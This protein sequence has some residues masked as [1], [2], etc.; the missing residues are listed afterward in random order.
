MADRVTQAKLARG[1]FIEPGRHAT[2]EP[3]LHLLVRSAKNRQW[4]ARVTFHGRRFDVSIGPERLY[5]LVEARE[6]CRKIARAAR[7]GEDPRLVLCK[8]SD[9]PPTFNLRGGRRARL[10]R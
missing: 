5:S 3:C 10:D 9:Q 7:D 2:G 6:L 1:G 4:I 8:T